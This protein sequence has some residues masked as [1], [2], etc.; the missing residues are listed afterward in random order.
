MPA[1]RPEITAA[2]HWWAAR[3]HIHYNEAAARITTRLATFHHLW[4]D[5]QPD[6]GTGRRLTVA[7]HLVPGSRDRAMMWIDPGRM[8]VLVLGPDGGGC[9]R[10]Q[11]WSTAE[12]AYRADIDRV[13]PGSDSRFPG[14]RRV[15]AIPPRCRPL[16]QFR[17]L[18]RMEI[19]YVPALS[20]PE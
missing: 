10:A 1:S 20:P 6:I 11:P 16:C 9:A 14:A 13:P 4:I 3:L 19:A 17:P 8:L 2:A 18:G 15:A 12:R 5:S 7:Q